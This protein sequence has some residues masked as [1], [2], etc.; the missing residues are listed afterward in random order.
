M[1]PE[2]LRDNLLMHDLI[3]NAQSATEEA[4]QWFADNHKR[5]SKETFDKL[6]AAFHLLYDARRTFDDKVGF[7]KEL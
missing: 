6:G 7:T 2:T 3:T 4:L 5:V 1:N